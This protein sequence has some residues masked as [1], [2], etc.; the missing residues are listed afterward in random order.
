VPVTVTDGV[1]FL[2]MIAVAVFATPVPATPVFA[3]P[4][5]ASARANTIP[6][7]AERRKSRDPFSRFQSSSDSP[8]GSSRSA[9]PCA[10]R[11]ASSWWTKYSTVLTVSSNLP[12]ANGDSRGGPSLNR[13][14]SSG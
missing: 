4:V 2:P 14:I 7:G 6:V 12:M 8:L 3:T 9:Q 13:S 1:A 10:A 11:R 5:L